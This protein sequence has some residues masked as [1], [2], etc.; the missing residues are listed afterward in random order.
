MESSLKEA[1]IVMEDRAFFQLG[2]PGGLI[3]YMLSR[4][5]YRKGE[6]MTLALTWIQVRK[7]RRRKMRE[8]VAMPE[9]TRRC[10]FAFLCQR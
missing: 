7:L 8:R 1:G 9:R 2:G 5:N 10:C 6:T 3:E 4:S